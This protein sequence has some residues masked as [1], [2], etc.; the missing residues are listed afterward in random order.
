MIRVEL[1]PHLLA[2]SFEPR[3]AEPI[4]S[5]LKRNRDERSDQK[6]EQTIAYMLEHLNQALPV[7]KLAGIASMSS[8]HYT[9]L[10][11][12]HTGCTPIDYFI[13]LRM[14]HA[15]GLLTGTS[16]NVKEVAA[17]LGYED[18]FYFSRVFKAVNQVAPS[19]YRLIH[20]GEGNENVDSPCKSWFRPFHKNGDIDKNMET[21]P[22]GMSQR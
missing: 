22:V 7:A 8:S 12:R 14:R 11:K 13:R 19:E 5:Q 1:D 3:V 6:I 9:A 15:C 20:K 4:D 21:S 18:P 2:A 17:A 10:F 16:L